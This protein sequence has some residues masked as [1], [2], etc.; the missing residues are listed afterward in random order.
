[1]SSRTPTTTTA[2]VSS[3]PTAM[4]ARFA[5][6]P[7]GRPP[8][9]PGPPAPPA[10]A[11]PSGGNPPRPPAPRPRGGAPA[12][13]PLEATGALG[14][15]DDRGEAAGPAA[16]VAPPGRGGCWSVAPVTERVVPATGL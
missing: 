13:G 4:R 11:P 2:I 16:I 6:P 12:P 15:A 8:G 10:P 1:M 9:A 7:D 5:P 14:G 3:T